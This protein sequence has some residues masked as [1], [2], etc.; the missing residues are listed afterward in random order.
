[1]A[2]R[3]VKRS[4]GRVL[5]A[6]PSKRPPNEVHALAEKIIDVSRARVNVIVSVGARQPMLGEFGS[7]EVD[8]REL[9]SCGMSLEDQTH[10]QKPCT[11]D[12]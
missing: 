3:A 4:I 11:G 10:Q 6:F 2:A 12:S 9:H 5:Q 7:G 8:A 1:M